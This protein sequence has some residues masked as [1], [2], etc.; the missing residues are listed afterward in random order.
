MNCCWLHYSALSLSYSFRGCRGKAPEK[1]IVKQHL[2]KF[3][4]VLTGLLWNGGAVILWRAREKV[5]QLLAWD[6]K[7]TAVLHF[8]SLSLFILKS[9][10]LGIESFNLS[11][12]SPEETTSFPPLNC[13]LFSISNY[14]QERIFSPIHLGYNY[15]PLLQ[16]SFVLHIIFHHSALFS[17]SCQT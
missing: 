5:N 14:F 11:L 12:L 4:L 3:G 7:V 15:V 8:F 17:V 16:S 13:S 6:K 1:P 10:L 2:F 9:T